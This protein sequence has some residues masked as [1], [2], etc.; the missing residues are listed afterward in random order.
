[1]MRVNTSR[2]N[3]EAVYRTATTVVEQATRLV[4]N[5]A[6]LDV[7]FARRFDT[8]TQEFI[9]YWFTAR[10]RRGLLALMLKIEQVRNGRIRD[11]LM[12]A[13]SRTIIAKF[14]GVSKAID[15]PHTRP[16]RVAAKVTPDPIQAFPVRLQQLMR[17]IPDS[18]LGVN[19]ASI[20]KGDARRIPLADGTVDLVLT[21]S[22]Y[23]NA[24]DYIRAHKFSLIWMRHSIEKLREVRSRMIGAELTM[25]PSRDDLAWLEGGLPVDLFPRRTA[26]LRKFFYD[27]DTVMREIHRV[28]RTGGACVLVVGKSTLGSHVVNTPAILARIAQQIGF[29][30]LGTRFRQVN[31]LRRSLPFATCGDSS[32]ALRK[33]MAREA[34]VCLGK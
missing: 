26:I 32:N 2:F 12:L 31:P 30:H 17:R 13:F 7:R 11:V 19:R 8:E 33:R 18:R 25:T 4:T 5:N 6:Y 15:L 20:R 16:H 27:M 24:I 29:K 1:M 23:A 14:A 10:S 9:R 3:H 22:P 28:L 34:I 21:S